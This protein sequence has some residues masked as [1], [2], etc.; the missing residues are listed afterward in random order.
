MNAAD[1]ANRPASDE[2]PVPSP[3]QLVLPTV[4][5]MLAQLRDFLPAA[6]GSTLGEATQSDYV[7][8][9]CAQAL[10]VVNLHA[11]ARVFRAMQTALAHPVP[12]RVQRARALHAAADAV[13]EYLKALEISEQSTTAEPDA[14]AALFEPYRALIRLG[15][16]DTAQASDLWNGPAMPLP[17]LR[18]ATLAAQGV[19]MPQKLPQAT[20]DLRA[21]L[22]AQVLELV[23]TAEPASAH[24][25]SQLCLRLAEQAGSV[26]LEQFWC[27]AAAWFEGL[28]R[29]R[30]ELDVAAKRLASRL[31]LQYAI[32]AKGGMHTPEALMRELL[33][34]CD[35]AAAH[36]AQPLPVLLHR[37]C[38]HSAIARPTLEPD[39]PQSSP[40]AP[41][42]DFAA[43]AREDK[44][45]FQAEVAAEVS[46]EP[47]IEPFYA[48][49]EATPAPALLSDVDF[50]AIAPAQKAPAVVEARAAEISSWAEVA[51]ESLPETPAAQTAP[52]PENLWRTLDT[53]KPVIEPTPAPEVAAEPAPDLTTDL[54]PIPDDLIFPLD[55]ATAPE[56]EFALD[57]DLTLEA[58]ADEPPIWAE[59]APELTPE[60][61]SEAAAVAPVQ[62]TNIQADIAETPALEANF[63]PEARADET[64][65]QAEVAPKAPP[66]PEV[67]QSAVVATEAEAAQASGDPAQLHLALLERLE[68]HS[69]ALETT[70][71]AWVQLPPTRGK[72][73]AGD[74]GD[75][76]AHLL[77][78]AVEHTA[79]LV[80]QTWTAGAPDIS[81]LARTIEQSLARLH[82][83]RTPTPVRQICVRAA[84]EIER[85]LF[86]FAAKTARRA[87]PQVVQTM[88]RLATELLAAPVQPHAQQLEEKTKNTATARAE[89]NPV[90]A[91]VVAASD[92]DAAERGSDAPRATT[93]VPSAATNDEALANPA[94]FAV[95]DEEF[96][97]LW[98]QLRQAQADW[99]RAV[100]RQALPSSARA[101]D[102]NSTQQTIEQLQA[103]A[104]ESRQTTLRALHTLKA[105]AQLAGAH[106]WGQQVH[107]IESRALEPDLD[108]AELAAPLQMLWA[109]C[110]A[111]TQ[112]VALRHPDFADRS[113]GR[114]E[115]LQGLQRLGQGL[116]KNHARAQTA[117]A[118]AGRVLAEM[119]STLARL[120]TL[121]HRC[122]DWA[123]A[124][125]LQTQ[126]ELP[127]EL[128]EDLGDLLATLHGSEEDLGTIHR[129][130]QHGQAHTAGVLAEQAAQLQTLQN[131]LLEAQQVPLASLEPRLRATAEVAQRETGRSAQILIE[132]A[133]Q[134]LHRDTAQALA[135][136]LDHL[137]R[138][139]F[140]HGL[141]DAAV[142]RAA[143]KPETGCITLSLRSTP[144]RQTLTIEDD[145][146]GLDVDAIW[147]KAQALG[148]IAP[149]LDVPSDAERQAR[150]AELICHPG[151]STAAELTG[152][153]GRGIGMDAVD[154]GV[155]AIGGQLRID[156]V[157]GVGCRFHIT[158]PATARVEPIVALTLAH[159][160][161][162]HWRM[163]VPEGS[164]WAQLHISADEADAALAAGLLR[165]PEHG[166]VPLYAA[167]AVWGA[168]RWADHAGTDD[169]QRSAANAALALQLPPG[170]TLTQPVL[171][172][173]GPTGRWA[174]LV[175]A[176]APSQ[177]LI[178]EPP[179][180]LRAE[181]P[182]GLLGTAAEPSGQVLQ[183]WDAA[184]SVLA[185]EARLARAAAGEDEADAFATS[186][187]PQR[188]RPLVML[189]DDSLSVRR[190]AQH[191]LQE[192]GYAV[193]TFADA[194][195][196]LERLEN[197]AAF[198]LQTAAH[199]SVPSSIEALLERV[200]DRVGG[201]DSQA[202]DGQVNA[203]ATSNTAENTAA[204]AQTP[205]TTNAILGRGLMGETSGTQ[206]LHPSPDMLL[207]DIEMPDMNGLDLLRKLRADDRWRHLPIVMLTAHQPGPVSHKAIELGAQA[208]LTKPYSPEELLA[209]VRRYCA[210]AV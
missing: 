147:A 132:G 64:L 59:V 112:A 94:T 186:D 68:H 153:A 111:L 51:P 80:R 200:A 134:R 162:G 92:S 124:L 32:Q 21:E 3:R 151:L 202:A 141:E 85:M 34:R 139:S 76:A 190:L 16:A 196:A 133:S 70:L 6:D 160:Q 95:F 78:Q 181:P 170:Q 117:F 143:H 180:D 194:F 152:L 205:S 197:S 137:V 105:S 57:L 135:P 172:V 146:A 203:A 79:E 12:D 69:R 27:L 193:V 25:L 89:E 7:M 39:T 142:R 99:Q 108:P 102:P 33:Y 131:T 36:S 164:I 209:Q 50:A 189:V 82:P 120:H 179:T 43:T 11:S 14:I 156:S 61:G 165:H 72:A 31:L 121:A 188:T 13:G 40:I 46:L 129:Q 86:Q 74:S 103:I 47:P 176:A 101:S 37:V 75:D 26:A 24:A 104:H 114:A 168:M 18:L 29:G 161:G 144:L 49:A 44:T 35:R 167:S 123:D 109:D 28:Q 192:Q 154:A 138:N 55:A 198:V 81:T 98:P 145:G 22:D 113:Q 5:A 175:D 8:Q 20:A 42:A 184:A 23:K 185:H 15:G 87:N 125:M 158:L 66:A 122:A 19:P 93:P 155:R 171:I 195:E 53:L 60:I 126:L 83:Q 2:A 130:L 116:W 100:Q 30:A 178:I 17:T 177:P 119:Q 157:R 58:R 63:A 208:W 52:V 73:L 67:A 191:L 45:A 210:R 128:H 88:Q 201:H 166:A 54:P 204:A 169:A 207:V 182:A 106:A 148:L 187:S 62:E 115:P 1:H 97:A 163:G 159:P 140:A 107:A 38:E 4:A 56:A 173:R 199:E 77:R 90:Q 206:P 48:S 174:L 96:R 9:Q 84:A 149:S 150:A 110:M 118:D 41:E 136:L 91:E 71:L 183:V 65:I 10:Q 127:Y